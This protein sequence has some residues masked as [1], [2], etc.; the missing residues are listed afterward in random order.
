MLGIMSLLTHE[1]VT[2]AH[3]VCGSGPGLHSGPSEPIKM[4]DVREVPPQ[5]RLTV[6]TPVQVLRVTFNVESYKMKVTHSSTAIF[7][8]YVIDLLII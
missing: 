8:I 3:V 2:A 5:Q 6:W 4:L 7:I 1:S